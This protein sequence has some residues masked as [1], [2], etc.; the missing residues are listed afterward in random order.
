MKYSMVTERGNTNTGRRMVN[1]PLRAES[2]LG[3]QLSGGTG[4]DYRGAVP[5]GPQRRRDE[6]ML[7]A[8]ALNKLLLNC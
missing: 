3:G 2:E 1:D 6:S 8:L 5:D 7:S 4:L